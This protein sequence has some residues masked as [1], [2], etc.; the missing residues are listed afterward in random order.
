M[1]IEQID[2]VELL[3]T[4][5]LKIKAVRCSVTLI[6]IYNTAR[7]HVLED[8]NPNTH[9]SENLKSNTIIIV[10]IIICF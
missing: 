5:V 1:Q 7:R 4:S 10:I 2:E 3:E 9:R 8:S 6:A